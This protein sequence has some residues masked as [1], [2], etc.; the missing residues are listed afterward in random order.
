MCFPEFQLLPVSYYNS[1][2][3]T[4]V[5]GSVSREATCT[6]KRIW[7]IY[8]CALRS[9]WFSASLLCFVFF[10]LRLQK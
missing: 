6:G 7:Q 5:L 10:F 3:V 4:L 1:K 2:A 9:C 8:N